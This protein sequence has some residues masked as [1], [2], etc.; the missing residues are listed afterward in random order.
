VDAALD[1]CGYPSRNT[2]GVPRGANLTTVSSTCNCLPPNTEWSPGQLSILGPT[3]IDHL[4]IPG[5]VYFVTSD[6]ANPASANVTIQYSRIHGAG[7]SSLVDLQ[8]AGHVT[9]KNSDITGGY[10]GS[11]CTQPPSYGVYNGSSANVLD[12]DYLSCEAQPINAEGWTVTSSF[13]MVDGGS[14]GEAVYIAGGNA[15]LLG[16]TLLSANG[17]LA[18]VFGETG[19]SALA[20]VALRNNLIATG[21]SNGTIAIGCRD[22]SVPNNGHGYQAGIVIQNNRLAAVF[23]SALAPGNTDGGPGTAWSG[24]FRDAD[25][26]AVSQP[27]AAC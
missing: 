27:V 4:D 8:G 24:N 23:G 20:N 13:A 16:N 7:G 18:G 14:G 11:T 6:F 12:H 3:T 9:I 10:S 5:R 15:T 2:A 19:G 17:A 25:L 21:G 26:S 22:G 1:S